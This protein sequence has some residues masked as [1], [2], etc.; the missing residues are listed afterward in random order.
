MNKSF[1]RLAAT[2]AAAGTI[3]VLIGT[4]SIGSTGGT[5]T[6]LLRAKAGCSVSTVNGTK[7]ATV[8]FTGV[9]NSPSDVTFTLTIKNKYGTS[10]P[11]LKVKAGTTDK[12]VRTYDTSVY[13][14]YAFTAP[15]MAPLRVTVSV[16]SC[17]FYGAAN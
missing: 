15:H 1:A 3:L 7:Q 2:V 11:L 14:H 8:I 17:R 16:P 10:T 6:T 4:A 12:L 9:N 5:Y 13:E